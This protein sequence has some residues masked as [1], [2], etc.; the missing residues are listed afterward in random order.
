M[1]VDNC[2]RHFGDWWLLGSKDYPDWGF[3][4]FDLCNQF[5][6][7]ALTGGL[8][9]LI[10]FIAIYSRSF[11]AIGR[12]RKQAAGDR[13]EEWFLWCLG[14]ALFAN[15]VASFG[16]NYMVHLMMCFFSLLACIS[17]GAFAPRSETIQHAGAPRTEEF[18]HASA[19]AGW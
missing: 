17:V 12:A 5:V 16:I 7:A 6:V 4:M 14:S 11:G 15:V 13:R 18:A 19:P 2:I 3:V 10:V 8:V 9:T 1:L